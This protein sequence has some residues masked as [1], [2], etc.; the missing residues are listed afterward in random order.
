[1]IRPLLVAALVGIPSVALA[2]AAP[3]APSTSPSSSS[4]TATSAPTDICSSG[5]SS[6]VSRPSQTTAACVVKSNQV[7]IETGW[8]SQTVV[9]GN[10]GS[11]TYQSGPNATIRIGTS[12][13]NV[14]FDVIPPTTLRSSGVTA[15]SDV[16][17]G[18]RWQI[19]STPTVAYGF[20]TIVTGSTGTNPLTNPNGLG[21]ANTGTYIVNAN[22]QGAL[23]SKFG[24]GA[25]FSYDSLAA[26]GTLGSTRYISMV[27]SVDFSYS[28][29]ASWTL[30]VEGY[31]QTN[32]EGP[33]TP[34]H[35]WFDTALMK[36]IGNA[37]LDINYG[38]SNGITPIYG[39]PSV[40][41]RYVGAGLSYLL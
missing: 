4:T 24:Y 9:V 25:T 18:L 23:S 39:G 40:Q 29:P 17:A 35:T 15:L 38:V 10:G 19:Y 31:R 7:L 12:L 6:I 3:T 13:K 26:A 33:D 41:R 28:M 36:D 14:E 27:P 34:G 16:G 8:Q 21:S 32:G 37:Q 5:L 1:V 30:L 22:V 2:Q 11:Y 20:N